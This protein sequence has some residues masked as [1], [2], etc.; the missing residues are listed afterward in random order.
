MYSKGVGRVHG[1]HM[2]RGLRGHWAP[3]YI[4]PECFLPQLSESLNLSIREI[5]YQLLLMHGQTT[6]ASTLAQKY[7]RQ[8]HTKGF[9]SLKQYLRQDIAELYRTRVTEP[10]RITVSN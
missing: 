2:A 3:H 9:H 5:L 1:G 6:S 4:D 8:L 10:M 7:A